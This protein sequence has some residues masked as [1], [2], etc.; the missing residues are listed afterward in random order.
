MTVNLDLQQA[1]ALLDLRYQAESGPRLVDV[2]RYPASIVAALERK[3]LLSWDDDAG[4][5]VLTALGRSE[6]Y[7]V[8]AA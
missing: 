1:N 3:G 2:E 4:R 5:Y 8:V 7:K 6:P